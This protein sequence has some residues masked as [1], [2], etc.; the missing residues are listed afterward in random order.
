MI[1]IKD[2]SVLISLLQTEY[3]SI[4]IDIIV[5]LSHEFPNRIVITCGYR[6]GDPGVHGTN[7]CRGI[8]IRSW[9]FKHP[10]KKVNYINLC[11]EYDSERPHKRVAIFHDVGL[12]SHLHIQSHPNTRRR[13]ETV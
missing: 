9:T 4:L 11:W 10:A 1:P 7:P 8:D 3:D 12:G 13:K 5:W 6:P 2:S